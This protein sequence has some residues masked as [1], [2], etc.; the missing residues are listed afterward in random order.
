MLAA[1]LLIVGLTIA[2]VA[3]SPAKMSAAERSIREFYDSYAADLRGH[4]RESIADRYDRRGVYLAGN[5][6]KSLETF[7]KIKDRYLN[8]WSGPKA[9]IW[10]DLSVE[11]ISKDSAVVSALFEWQVES[12]TTFTYSYTGLLIKRDGKWRIRLEDESTAPSKTSN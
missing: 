7:D 12:G 9:F 2:A 8:D 10:K 3:K 1:V 5:G 4:K 11:V 6:R